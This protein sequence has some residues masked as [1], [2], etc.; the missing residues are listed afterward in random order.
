VPI[1]VIS[2]TDYDGRIGSGMGS[3]FQTELLAEFAYNVQFTKTK[4]LMKI[5]L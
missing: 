2:A 5:N 3:R 1:L 4:I